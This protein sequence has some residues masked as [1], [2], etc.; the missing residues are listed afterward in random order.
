MAKGN[1]V[2][3]TFGGQL[4]LKATFTLH[5]ATTPK[6]IDYVIADGPDK[7]KTQLGIYEL[8]AGTARFCFAPPGQPRPAEFKTNP[9][10]G[11]TVSVWKRATK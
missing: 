5:A 9:G 2:T 11:R 1:D 8:D 4:F 3:I 10:D 6:S 7:G